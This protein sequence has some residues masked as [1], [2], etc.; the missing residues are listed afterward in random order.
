MSLH[1]VH[2]VNDKDCVIQHLQG[3]L[4]FRR[5]IHVSRGIQKRYLGVSQGEDGLFGK[6]GDAAAALQ[7]IG[8]QVC[9]L[10]V[11]TAGL[12]NPAA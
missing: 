9:V 10:V 11:Y 7:F 6:D 8:V 3:A 1:S 12:S 2:S 4:H 5:E